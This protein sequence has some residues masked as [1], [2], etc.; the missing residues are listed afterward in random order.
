[1]T[2]E[3]RPTGIEISDL[4]NVCQTQYGRACFAK[5]SIDKGTK[6]LCTNTGI[7]STI[8]HEFRKEVCANCFRYEYGKYAKVK[9]PKPEG[10][11]KSKFLGAGLWFC[12]E[13]CLEEWKEQDPEGLLTMTYEALLVHY[14]MRIKHVSD[15]EDEKAN[16]VVITKDVIDTNWKAIDEWDIKIQNMKKQKRQNHLPALNEEEYSSSKFVALALF[17]ILNHHPSYQ[18]FEELQTNEIEKIS[19]YPVLLKSQSSVFKFLRI[20]LPEPLQQL[21][22][23]QL[24]RQIFGR[25]Y[26]NSFAIRQITTDDST[27]NKEFLGYLMSPEASFFNH[28]CRPNLRKERFRNHMI[29]KATKDIAPGEQLCIDYYQLLDEPYETR[30]R[31]LAANWFFYCKCDR[32][33][34][35]EHQQHQAK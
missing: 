15:E 8:L 30:Q 11:G 29:F 17:N 2:I 18:I 20:T 10:W 4:F 3:E 25:E 24:I 21:L 12:S 13:D 34:E 19:K 26:G 9:L 1:M 14:Q 28:S 31:D 7:G 27:E 5:S 35:E 22:T 32:C 23:T 16:K 6:V 33:I